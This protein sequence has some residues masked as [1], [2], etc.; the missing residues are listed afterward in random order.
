VRRVVGILASPRPLTTY[1]GISIIVWV[2][3]VGLLWPH[4]GAM[5]DWDEVD[6]V[7][8]AKLGSSANALESGSLWPLEFL[9]FALSKAQGRD[10]ILPDEY[11]ES[12]DPFIL[13]HFHPPFVVFLLTTI[14][15]SRSERVIR[16]VQVLG[17]LLLILAMML[18]YRIISDSSGW[19]GAVVVSL[20]ALWIVR[21]VFASVS[22][23]GW[24]AIWST[25]AAVLIARLCPPA[26]APRAVLWIGLCITL[27]V[28]LLTLETG[29]AVWLAAVLWFVGFRLAYMGH[30]R[31][32][33]GFRNLIRG[34]LIALLLIALVWPAVIVKLSLLKTIAIYAYRVQLGKEYMT[35][36]Y[37]RIAR[38][39]LPVLVLGPVLLLWLLF[40][41]RRDCGRWGP[42]AAVAS[43]YG[44]SVI[45]FA[46][47]PHYLG[48]AIAPLACVVGYACDRLSRRVVR[49]AVVGLT[50]L[51]IAVAW[52]V[53]KAD[54]KS[55][56]DLEWLAGT[57]RGQKA[58]VDG[59]HIYQFYLGPQYAIQSVTVAYDGSS[60]AVRERGHYRDLRVEDVAG[61]IVVIRERVPNKGVPRPLEKCPWIDR[62]TVR[63]YDCTDGRA[64]AGSED[65][66][67][68][69]SPHSPP[70]A[71]DNVSP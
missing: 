49:L 4:H 13:R 42:F 8:A 18:S 21:L 37:G 3:A 10:P 55:R 68:A 29:L 17:S 7:N 43:V 16:S 31:M 71:P 62:F 41:A 69:P 30:G 47:Q 6:Y 52:P 63:V 33:L 11:D 28:S 70:G 23:H 22:F 66:V 59:G 67:V 48:P 26:G 54:Q 39:V 57:L 36:S 45:P 60:I 19:A 5:L 32:G 20:F 14:S 35:V 40:R 24:E 61:L 25:T 58:L 2:M 51:T 15:P 38:Q 65:R 12:L 27:A 1:L 56:H 50:C 64:A 34:V 44:M 53:G 9:R 46:L